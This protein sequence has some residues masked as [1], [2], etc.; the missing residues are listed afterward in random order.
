MLCVGAKL[1]LL[2]EAETQGKGKYEEIFLSTV[3]VYDFAL[4][5]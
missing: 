5:E 2:N 4:S 3:I 1:Y